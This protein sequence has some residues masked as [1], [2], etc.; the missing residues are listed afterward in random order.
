MYDPEAVKPMWEELANVGVKPLTTADDVDT[1][2]GSDAK[3]VTM[4]VINSVCG[5]AA[6][7]CRP[8]VTLAL[9]NELIPDD[10]VTVFAGMDTEA[11][12]KARGYLS[13]P[14]SS[15]NIA[16]FKDGEL[17]AALQRSHIERMSAL[18]IGQA[19]I[20]AFN[21]HC[22]R[23]GP[24]V[25]PEVFEDNDSVKQCGSTIPLYPGD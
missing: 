17:V 7:G 10:S 12:E 11:V 18:D 1:M 16:I 19:L 14:P 15:P 8:G 23:K 5:C 24:S 6:G 3:G 20:G 2:L 4:L 22:T 13:Y 25:P 21:E 9:Q